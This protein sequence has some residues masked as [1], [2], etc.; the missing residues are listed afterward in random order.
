M[1]NISNEWRY[2]CYA[3]RAVDSVLWLVHYL[4]MSDVTDVSEL[5]AVC[6]RTAVFW[7]GQAGED[8]TERGL[9]Q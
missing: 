8:D 4:D 3:L 6:V 7:N 5:Q 1:Q 9:G 2:L